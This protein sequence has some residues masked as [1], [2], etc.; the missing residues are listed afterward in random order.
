MA[1]HRDELARC[2][3][4]GLLA[5]GIPP[6]I[7]LVVEA[8]EEGMT[9]RFGCACPT[10]DVGIV[11]AID[12]LLERKAGLDILRRGGPIPGVPMHHR[13]RAVGTYLVEIT[14]IKGL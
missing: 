1:P 2:I 4:I 6:A 7:H 9:P 3:A 14:G 13:D 5:P 8:Q 10:G 11:A 12:D